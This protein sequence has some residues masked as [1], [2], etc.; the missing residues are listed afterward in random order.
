MAK[1]AEY[2]ED[3]DLHVVFPKRRV[4]VRRVGREEFLSLLGTGPLPYLLGNFL[5]G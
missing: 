5:H 3:K 4:V 2:L 1:L